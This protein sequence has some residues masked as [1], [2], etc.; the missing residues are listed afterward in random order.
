[1]YN[2]MFYIL[3]YCV[4]NVYIV[5]FIYK[6]CIIERKFNVI[7]G[8]IYFWI[9]DDIVFLFDF[10]LQIYYNGDGL[11]LFCFLNDVIQMD[12]NNIKL[13]YFIIIF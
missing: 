4:G 13:N 6:V 7:I 5:I 2:V 12:F 11:V 10:L 3:W 1:M 8:R 9:K